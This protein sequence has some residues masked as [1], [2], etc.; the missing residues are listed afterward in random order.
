MTTTCE[1][2]PI[3]SS[4]DVIRAPERDVRSRRTPGRRAAGDLYPIRP[5][6]PAELP[7]LLGLAAQAE[8]RA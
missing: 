2:D 3:P 5:R 1:L 6:A 8:T 7:L 4:Q